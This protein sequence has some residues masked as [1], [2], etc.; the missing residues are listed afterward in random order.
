MKPIRT[1]H[2]FLTL[3]KDHDAPLDSQ[4]LQV[5][6]QGRAVSLFEGTTSPAS[7]AKIN[8]EH[9]ACKPRIKGNPT[10]AL[11]A[12]SHTA[13]KALTSGQAIQDLKSWADSFHMPSK[14]APGAAWIPCGKALSCSLDTDSNI[15]AEIANSSASIDSSTILGSVVGGSSMQSLGTATSSLG[16]LGDKSSST[17]SSL[18]HVNESFL[19]NGRTRPKISREAT[20]AKDTFFDGPSPSVYS[21]PT[22]ISPGGFS[23]FAF[24]FDSTSPICEEPADVVLRRMSGQVEEVEK[25]FTGLSDGVEQQTT[26]VMMKEQNGFEPKLKRDKVSMQLI[27]P[28]ARTETQDKGEFVRSNPP[29]EP[30]WPLRRSSLRYAGKPHFLNA[31]EQ[32]KEYRK[33]FNRDSSD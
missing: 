18:D 10:L 33:I 31:E 17:V 26:P 32:A 9:T 19:Q 30:V 12:P 15:P 23:D 16:F 13:E 28:P 2:S 1:R 4:I 5:S 21:R 27:S 29:T 24:G 20:T 7:L 8:K 25:M 11:R 14:I 3:K 22:N 6:S